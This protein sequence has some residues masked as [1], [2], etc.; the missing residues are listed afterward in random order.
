VIIVDMNASMSTMITLPF[1]WVIT[2]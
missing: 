2:R 1:R